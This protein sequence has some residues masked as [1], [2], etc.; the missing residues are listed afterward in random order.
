[1][2]T[3]FSHGPATES[4]SHSGLA[5]N[6]ATDQPRSPTTTAGWP[7]IQ[8]RTS[9]GV[10]QPRRAGPKSSHGPATES[11]SHVGLAPNAA[12]YQPW[13]PATTLTAYCLLLTAKESYA[14][15]HCQRSFGFLCPEPA[16]MFFLI[17]LTLGSY[18]VWPNAYKCLFSRAFVTSGCTC[19]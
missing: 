19:V 5:P 8:P 1:M 7:R 4:S 2:C 14:G 9:H 16:V 10:Q 13:N 11:S 15:K 3:G 17:F 18:A 12:T 6:P